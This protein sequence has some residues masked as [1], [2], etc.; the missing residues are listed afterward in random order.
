MGPDIS[1]RS[2][3]QLGAPRGGQEGLRVC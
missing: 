1:K 2:L 3:V